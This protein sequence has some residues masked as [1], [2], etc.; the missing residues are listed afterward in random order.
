[1]TL[2]EKID[3]LVS[4]LLVNDP[5]LHHQEPQ[6]RHIVSVLLQ[7][8]PDAVI[9]DRFRKQLREQLQTLSAPQ[10][11]SQPASRFSVFLRPLAFSAG[12]AAVILIVAVPLW[13]NQQNGTPLSIT[14]SNSI[15]RLGTN[16]FGDLSAGIS[17]SRDSASKESAGGSVPTSASSNTLSQ[18]IATSPSARP[19]P[20]AETRYRYVYAGNFPAVTQSSDVVKRVKNAKAFPSVSNLNEF[21]LNMIGLSS[22]PNL[23]MA[24]IQFTDGQDNGYTI[25]VNAQEGTAMISSAA[26]Y[27]GKETIL[28]CDGANCDSS[29]SASSAV[30]ALPDEEALT[31]ANQ[32]LLSHAI[33]TQG[34]GEPAVI[35]PYAGIDLLALDSRMYVPETVQVV[36]PLIINGVSVYTASGD[37]MGMQVAVSS[38][39]RSVV[40]VS[41]LIEHAYASSS[42]QNETD[43]SVLQA[44]M[45]RG[46]MYDYQPETAAQTVDITLRDPRIAYLSVAQYSGTEYEEL[47]VPALIFDVDPGDTDALAWKKRVIVPLVKDVI[48]SAGGATGVGVAEPSVPDTAPDV[49]GE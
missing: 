8:K 15:T 23:T 22:F 24:N 40:S 7:A 12:V 16:A 10:F 28:R 26:L 34:Y 11:T 49:V 18:D 21:G 45:E 3:S 6:V 13:R 17:G 41:T 47:Y 39:T 14:V 36:F 48:I 30:D 19:E 46:G 43:R 44:I 29:A 9:N 31:I 25:D 1:M 33:S 20:I 2:Q 5:K 42:Y 38:R 32:F 4:E 27:G 37:L 35:D